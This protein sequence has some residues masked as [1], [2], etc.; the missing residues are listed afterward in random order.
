M[1]DAI[2]VEIERLRDEI[3]QLESRFENM[4][5]DDASVSLHQSHGEYQLE[6]DRLESEIESYQRKI[7][8]D[9]NCS[10]LKKVKLMKEAMREVATNLT[11]ATLLPRIRQINSEWS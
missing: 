11:R 5:Q 4:V 1:D 9:A 8:E 3:A 6:L 7:E 2:G 10:R